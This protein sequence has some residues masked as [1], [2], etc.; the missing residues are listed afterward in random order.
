MSDRVVFTVED[1][2]VGVAT[3]NRPDKLNA[4]DHALFQGLHQAANLARAAIGEGRV[5]AVLLRAEGRSFSSG[6]DV[7][8]FSEQLGDGAPGDDWI[9][10]LQQ[11]FTGIEDL[12]VPVVA[13]VQGVAFGGGCQLALAAHLRLA[14]PDA[15]LALLES[16][17]ALIPDLGGLTRL[18]RLIGLSRATDMAINAR[19]VDAQTAL[20][21]GLVDAVIDKD[22][23]DDAA[24]TYATRL[25]SGP[26][27][28]TGA[29]PALLRQSFTTGREEML[30]AERT[31]QQHCLASADF[32]EAATAAMQGRP[33]NFTGH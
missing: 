32:V 28:A 11:A 16:N 10:Y 14:A 22:C 29:V 1:S 17:W 18:P 31:H 30:M 8:L 13:A 21:W 4:M 26:T 23:F 6:L 19:K 7:S 27:V 25:A 12:P 33:A 24:R 5:R 2:G 20:A 3:L 15:E 9:A